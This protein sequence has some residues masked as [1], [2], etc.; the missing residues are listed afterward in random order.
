VMINDLMRTS[1][2]EDQL[3]FRNSA[4]VA[5]PALVPFWA[6]ADSINCML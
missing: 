1:L 4:R 3:H 5:V 2:Y 6:V